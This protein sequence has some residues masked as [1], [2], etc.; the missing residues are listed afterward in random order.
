MTMKVRALFATLAMLATLALSGCGHYVCTHTFGS[1]TCTAGSGGFSSG[2]TGSNGQTA[3]VYF[4]DNTSGTDG[5]AAEG[6][7]V[8]NSGTFAPISG[9][10]SP[11]LP[12]NVI[13]MTIVN[14]EFLYMPFND[15]ELG[16]YSINSS[17]GAL[18][19]IGTPISTGVVI[20][21]VAD[22]TGRFLFAGT[23]TGIAAYV[24]GSDGSL[25]LTGTVSTSHVPLQMA[26]DGLGKYLYAVDGTAVTAFSYSQTTGALTPVSGSPFSATGFSMAQVA[27]EPTGKYLIGITA[28]TGQNGG[29]TDNNVYVFNI[30]QTGGLS[31]ASGSPFAAV[32]SPNRLV[33]SPNGAFVYTFD[34]FTLASQS[35]SIEPMEGFSLNASTGALTSLGS[36][37]GLNVEAAQFDQSGTNLFAV[38]ETNSQL[39][40]TYVLTADPSSGAVAASS[41]P[42]AGAPSLLFAVT[43]EP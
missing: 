6:L 42:F 29:A 22:P 34:L 35:T 36:F 20:S 19:A 28:Q 8:A 4:V 13:S 16:A 43:D 15:E 18:T 41:L 37:D 39:F 7:N 17:S 12:D 38:M 31:A 14:K 2:G 21:T 40:S 24:I 30:S 5:M 33:V 9:F 1:A 26:T 10:V 11:T 25:T 32:A 3:F 27:G 23:T